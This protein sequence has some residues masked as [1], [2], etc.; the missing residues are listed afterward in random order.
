MRCVHWLPW[1][2]Q[3]RGVGE[4]REEIRNQRL[5]QAEPY[6]NSNNCCRSLRHVALLLLSFIS[7]FWSGLRPPP[8]WRPKLKVAVSSA[9]LKRDSAVCLARRGRRRRLKYLSVGAAWSA[10]VRDS[11][12]CSAVFA[13][14]GRVARCRGGW[15]EWRGVVGCLSLA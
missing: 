5:V 10:D 6:L 2:R 13:P 14:Q 11:G 7:P 9:G 4:R 8:R 15:R 1:L 12:P 3:S